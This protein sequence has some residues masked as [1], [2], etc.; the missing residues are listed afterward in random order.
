MMWKRRVWILLAAGLASLIF[1]PRLAAQEAAPAR[2]VNCLATPDEN[3]CQ[4]GLP[5]AQYQLYLDEMALN[6]RPKIMPLPPNTEELKRFKFRQLTNE[7]GTVIYDAPGGNA[8]GNMA[9]GFH[10]VTVQSVAEGWVEI[11]PGQW[12]VADDTLPYTPSSFAGFMFNPADW[13]HPVAWILKNEYPSAYAGGEAD[14]TL[15]PL[16]R[17]TVVHLYATV[18]GA[19]GWDWYLV[20]PRTWV[21]QTSV[22]RVQLI[23]RPEGFKGRWAAVDLYEQVMVAYEEDTPMFATL[24]SS[25]LPEW[26]TNEGTFQTWARISLDAMSGAEGQTDFYNLEAVP[27]TLYFDNAIS[28][29]G[30]YW[31][32]GFG[33]RRSHGCVNMSLS[34]SFWFYHWTAENGYDKPFV[35][36][37]SS[38]E[39]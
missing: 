28:L 2:V 8:I 33:Y 1:L 7:A 16:R 37:F 36:V 30:A 38:G 5:A 18:R 15:P 11:N 34:D 26:S 27:W 9:P 32:D 29:H 12:V 6:P 3:G 39:Y 14:S 17:Y 23:P 31:H 13:A 22:A 19:D 4:A 25:G 10:F 20:G 24:I 35:H 21:R